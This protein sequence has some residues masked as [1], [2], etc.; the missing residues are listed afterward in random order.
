MLAVVDTN[1]PP[2]GFEVST[3]FT[4][5]VR[6]RSG[7]LWK[8]S[9]G[10]SCGALDPNVG[11]LAQWFDLWARDRFG[12]LLTDLRRDGFDGPDLPVDYD[13][14][15]EITDAAHET[16]RRCDATP[17]DQRPAPPEPIHMPMPESGVSS[18]E[19]ILSRRRRPGP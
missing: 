13:L 6:D 17:L 11:D 8:Y 18:D 9:S 7:R 3:D 12:D 4:I 10:P 5:E 19:P 14:A 15:W 1:G 16:Q 2:G